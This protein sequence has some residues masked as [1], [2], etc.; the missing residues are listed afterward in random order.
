M[1]IIIAKSA[2]EVVVVFGKTLE[3]FTNLFEDISI[4]SNKL[5][6]R[7]KQARAVAISFLNG[8]KYIA[9][10]QFF[11]L[12]SETRLYRELTEVAS[13]PHW[14]STLES[15]AIMAAT[16]QG[17]TRIISLAQVDQQVPW[18]AASPM[19]TFA[20]RGPTKTNVGSV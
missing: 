17:A 10:P 9:F 4:I 16:R 14:R 6:S 15:L 19:N 13:T 3:S 18:L 5:S 2:D 1:A 8:S 12:S 11:H 7:C 20:N